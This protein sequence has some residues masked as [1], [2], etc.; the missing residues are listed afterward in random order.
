MPDQELAGLKNE[1]ELLKG[2]L[3]AINRRIDELEQKS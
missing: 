1:A 2:Q 3:E